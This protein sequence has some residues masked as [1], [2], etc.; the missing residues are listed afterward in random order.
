[1]HLPPQ[2][3]CSSGERVRRTPGLHTT[4]TALSLSLYFVFKLTA[5][6]T[7]AFN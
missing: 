2:I 1:V 3:G 6:I 5:T 7:W 4:A